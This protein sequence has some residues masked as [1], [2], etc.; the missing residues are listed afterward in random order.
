MSNSGMPQWLNI[1]E[2]ITWIFS[3]SDSDLCRVVAARDA[4]AMAQM[5]I[6][7]SAMRRARVGP[8]SL[9]GFPDITTALLAELRTSLESG[10][11]T[12]NADKHEDGGQITTA[13]IEPAEWPRWQIA[14][15]SSSGVWP[16][17]SRI[18]NPGQTLE[19]VLVNR[20][21]LLATF[22]APPS[23]HVTS[24]ALP[25]KKRGRRDK[26][27]WDGAQR[28]ARRLF[29]H[30]GMFT[31]DDKEW[32]CQTRL[33]KAIASWFQAEK[34]DEPVESRIREKVTEWSPHFTDWAAN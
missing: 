28:E 1:I 8:A 7:L 30:H 16:Q 4:G 5:S 31:A 12:A 27:D 3:R 19:R 6:A 14:F 13:K 25:A 10:A 9:G 33:E 15:G 2:A 23:R 20:N 17:A 11:V 22:N 26:Y 32:D 21:E 34:R 24:G 29:K 18:G